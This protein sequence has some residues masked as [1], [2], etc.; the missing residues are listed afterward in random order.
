MWCV[1]AFVF[2]SGRIP[3]QTN[4]IALLTLTVS[5]A[6]TPSSTD[7]AK[8]YCFVLLDMRIGLIIIKKKM[9]ATQRCLFLT[10]VSWL[11]CRFVYCNFFH[12]R[13]HRPGTVGGREFSQ[14]SVSRT[15][16]HALLALRI[17]V[18]LIVH[19]AKVLE[20]EEKVD[21]RKSYN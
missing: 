18:D 8:K 20:S 3:Q 9:V 7:S 13:S 15:V 5:G 10:S 11:K 1:V 6:E 17:K 12:D 21:G 14:R 19:S 2:K 4:W 16:L